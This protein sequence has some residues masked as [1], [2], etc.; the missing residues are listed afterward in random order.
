MGKKIKLPGRA[1]F[2]SWAF[3]MPLV[4]V[5][6]TKI[7]LFLRPL[8]ITAA[9]VIWNILLSFIM[10]SKLQK[11]S[12]EFLTTL[13]KEIKNLQKQSNTHL[14]ILNHIASALSQ[15]EKKLS[16]QDEKNKKKYN[17]QALK[18]AIRKLLTS[19]II[20]PEERKD[21]A[22]DLLKIGFYTQ[23]KQSALHPNSYF[24]TPRKQEK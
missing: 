11:P 12:E 23:V 6:L 8:I 2:L 21:S 16:L 7:T 13:S 3:W 5:M 24:K 9:S 20:I 10:H 18:L 17:R 22:Q 15:N 4:I 19:T 1:V 14:Q